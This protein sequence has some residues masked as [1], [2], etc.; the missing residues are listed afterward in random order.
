MHPATEH[1]LLD[2]QIAEY[3]QQNSRKTL[4]N[5]LDRFF[6]PKLLLAALKIAEADPEMRA[7]HMNKATRK[8]SPVC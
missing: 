6:P 7:A 2:M 5:M 4:K 1:N 8:N 3:A